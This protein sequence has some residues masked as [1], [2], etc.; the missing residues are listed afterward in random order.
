MSATAPAVAAAPGGR[1]RSRTAWTLLGQATFIVTQ[2]MVL[3]LLARLADIE[4]VGRFGYATAIVTPV[5]WLTDLGLRTN[6]TTDAANLNSFAD[7]LALRLLTTILGYGA[8]V[9]IA[10]L[11]TDD[12]VT[13]AITAVFG[14]AKGFEA[15]SDV[16]YGV[17]QRHGRLQLLAGAM[18]ARGLG[19]VAAFA[20]I[21]VLTGSVAGAFAGHLLVW[22]A[23]CLLYDL[24]RARR[25]SRDE[26]RG[27]R[28][29][30]LW[31]TVVE[32]L[33]L[34]GG[35]FLAA[36]NTALP[37]FFLESFAGIAALG[38]FT[39]VSY[40]LQATNMTMTAVSRS[41]AGHLAD[42]FEAGRLGAVRRIL[43]RYTALTLV[44]GAIGTVL[45]W[46]VG[47]RVLALVFG[48][49]LEGEGTVLMLILA[50]AVLRG[51]GIMLQTGPL[52]RR[53]FGAVLKVRI[54]D[55]AVVGTA[56]LAGVALAGIE[57]VA[58]A[59]ALAALVQFL[60][61]AAI[62][63]RVTRESPPHADLPSA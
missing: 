17:Y 12:A 3:V 55:L 31:P 6:K 26:P 42:L 50:A 62:A 10:A 30:R 13:L 40:L 22:A 35:Q 52:S 46:P 19:S 25:L 38:V 11:M 43:T 15:I 53:R 49:E 60:I 44:A 21:L 29:G 51:A 16:A 7:L 45:V 36:M 39:A 18:I 2:F 9:G 48:P 32:S 8:I 47:D 33:P 27:V 41:I 24:P 54:V 58:A 23:V 57:G 63:H 14:A 61:L 34:G 1:L 59:L 20:A 56:S 5:F 4:S 37:R 28:W